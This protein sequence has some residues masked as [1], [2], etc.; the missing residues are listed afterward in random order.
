MNTI[1]PRVSLL[2][3]AI[4][5]DEPLTVIKSVDTAVHE[6]KP[7]DA[8]GIGQDL[9]RYI[10]SKLYEPALTADK[11]GALAAYILEEAKKKCRGVWWTKHDSVAWS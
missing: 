8:I 6:A 9:A 3:A 1:K 10:G 5:K 11:A 4:R 7:F 2:T